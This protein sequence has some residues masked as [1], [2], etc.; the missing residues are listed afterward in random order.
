M[1]DGTAKCKYSFA[2]FRLQ[3]SKYS[4]EAQWCSCFRWDFYSTVKLWHRLTSSGSFFNL[5]LFEYSFHEFL[6]PEIHQIKF[7]SILFSLLCYDFDDIPLF[8]ILTINYK[9]RFKQDLNCSHEIYR[10]KWSNIWTI[11]MIVIRFE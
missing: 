5:R 3:S 6:Y 2:V 10:L 11:P 4:I 9:W 7:L 8:L 1:V